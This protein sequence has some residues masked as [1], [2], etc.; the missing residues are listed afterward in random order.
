[1]GRPYDK[2]HLALD[3]QVE[4]L[5]QRGMEVPD[6]GR[7]HRCL[8]TIGYYRLSGYYYPYRKPGTGGGSRRSDEFEPGTTLDQVLALYE[9]DRQLKLLVLDA[10]ERVEIMIRVKVGYVL[11]MRGAFAH[12]DSGCLDGNFTKVRE[13]EEQSQYAVWLE[14]MQQELD[15]SK[16]D[17]LAHFRE[18]YDGRLPVWVVTEILDFGSLSRL[19]S[20]LLR[21]DRDLIAKD[22]DILDGTGSGNGSVLANWLQVLN[23]VR[24]TCAHHSRLWNRNMTVQV[25]RKALRH[26]APLKHVTDGPTTTTDRV[27]GALC[28]LSFL[29]DHAGSA[30]GWRATVRVLLADQLPPS[31]R[32]PQEM[33]LPPGWDTQ[34]IWQ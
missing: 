12:L 19:Y 32:G 14:K 9:F 22:L 34:Q 33:G 5:R 31:M 1:V 10:V 15:R 4:R 3:Q 17:F 27:Y 7:A 13:G 23:F 11:G 18:T 16:E 8:A 21:A 29:L 25:G 30:V 2:P 20:G 6:D 28:V 26:I 24:N